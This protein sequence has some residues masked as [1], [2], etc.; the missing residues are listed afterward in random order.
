MGVW[1]DVKLLW[2][3]TCMSGEKL[4]CMKVKDGDT[5]MASEE[6]VEVE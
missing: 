1:W 6:R 4:D 5:I 3:E 2:E